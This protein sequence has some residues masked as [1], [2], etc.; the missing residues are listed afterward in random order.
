MDTCPQCSRPFASKRRRCY[1]CTGRKRTGIEKPC[2]VCG[3]PFYVQANV[4]ADTERNSG[5]Y[6]SWECRNAGIRG[7]EYRTKGDGTYVAA[8]GYRVV[9]V[10][11]RSRKLEHRLVMEQHLGRPLGR[12]EEV[13]HVNGDKLDNR[14]EN[15]MVLS[16]S[17]HQ[18]IH[19][20]GPAMRRLVTL[21]C[22]RCGAVFERRPK[23]AGQ[24]F[25]SHSCA[26]AA[27]Q[28]ARRKAS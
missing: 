27:T 25:C 7:K 22:E 6:C 12:R 16:P 24:R 15:L 19:N 28:E 21:T 4:A 9:K 2:A 26:S 14:V 10:G 17:E 1:F 3:K 20:F 5:T 11:C 23:R 13:H 18:K 8:T